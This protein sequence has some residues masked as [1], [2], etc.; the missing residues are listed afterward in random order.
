MRMDPNERSRSISKLLSKNDTGET[1]THQV[2]ILVPKDPE[3]LS[4][5]PPLAPRTK[6]PRALIR[7]KDDGGS[8]WDF[9]FI[10]YNNKFFGGTRNEYRLTCMTAFI[11]THS[12]RAGDELVLTRNDQDGTFHIS[13]T[14]SRTMEKRGD[15]VLRLGTEWRV[16]PIREV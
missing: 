9:P 12:L 3:I 15:G 7:F 8:T 5:F 1:G 2:G 10:Y 6:N 14:R 4:F 16:I 11:R 13:F